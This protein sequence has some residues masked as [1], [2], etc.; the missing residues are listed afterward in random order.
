MITASKKGDV[1]EGRSF[2][3]VFGFRMNV[4]YAFY[5]KPNRHAYIDA[6]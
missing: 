2:L 1:L 4:F 5:Y 6:D 3:F